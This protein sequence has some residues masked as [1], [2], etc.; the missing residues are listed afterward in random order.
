MLKVSI[1]IPVYNVEKYLAKCLE[2]IINQ[3]YKNLEIICVNDGSTD[4][5]FGILKDYAQKDERIQ[6]INRKNGGQSAAR[7]DGLDSTTGEY[8]YFVDS[9]DW[10]ELCTIEKLVKIITTYDVDAVEHSLIQ[11]LEDESCTDM[12]QSCQNY[13]DSLSRADGIYTVP[14]GI[15]SEITSLAWN[16]LYKMN[17]IREFHCR[18]PEG[19]VNEDELFLWDYMI[20]CNN[21]YYLDEKLYNYF[22]HVDSTMGTRDNSSKVLDMLEIQRRIYE[23]VKKYKNIEDYKEYLTCNYTSMVEGVFSRVPEKYRAKALEKVKEYYETVIHDKRIWKMYIKQKYRILVSL[24]DFLRIIFSIRNERKNGIKR[25]VVT[26]LG[27]KLKIRVNQKKLWKSRYLEYQ[28]KRKIVLEKLRKEKRKLRV[29]FLVSENE[30]WNAQSLYD[31]MEKSEDFYPF[32]VVTRLLNMWGR[33]SFQHN[34]EFFKNCCENVEVGFDEQTNRSIDLKSFKPDI[35]FYQ[36]PW[37]I[38]KN[39]SPVYILDCAL[40]YYFPY[41]IGSVSACLQCHLENF[42][43]ALQKH[44][45]FSEE[46]KNQCVDICDCLDLNTSVVGH[47]KLDVYNN[48]DERSFRKKYVIYAPHHSFPKDSLLNYGTFDWS[49][50]YIL[51]WAKSHPELNWVFKPHPSLKQTLLNSKLMTPNEIRKYYRDW[52]DLGICYNDGN[53]FDLFENSKCLITDCGSFLT[54]YFPTKNPVIHLRNPRGEDYSANNKIIMQTYY[55]AWNVKQLS[56]SLDDILLNGSDPKRE[57]RL[58]LLEKLNIG[59]DSSADRIIRELKKDLERKI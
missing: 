38:Y 4:N 39:Q 44:F 24:K 51:E 33:S 34:V 58:S 10:I 49:G 55:D 7:N 21:Y 52:E 14:I 29:C 43:L 6:I 25:K 30:K 57:E 36:Q 59:K 26:L 32:V 56:S 20:H 23:V 12:A 22:R 19:L 46:E 17:I 3:T 8:C 18:F 13:I 50:K 54:E 45:V 15:N 41:G 2:S 1:I 5:S 40:P 11:I 9:D 27:I 48:Y 42:Y 16:K 53:Y 35:V 28:Q 47:P 37:D 31:A